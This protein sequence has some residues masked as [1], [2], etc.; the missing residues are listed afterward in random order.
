MPGVLMPGVNPA[1]IPIEHKIKHTTQSNETL[2]AAG[3]Y[4]LGF[5]PLPDARTVALDSANAGRMGPLL[6]KWF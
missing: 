5:W 1:F 6:N 3:S 4:R 2:P